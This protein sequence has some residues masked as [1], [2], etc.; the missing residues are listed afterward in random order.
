[1]AEY[2]HHHYKKCNVTTVFLLSNILQHIYSISNKRTN[3]SPEM[4]IYKTDRFS[5]EVCWTAT[6]KK[7]KRDPLPFAALRCC[8]KPSLSYGWPVRS[9]ASE[10]ASSPAPRRP[11]STPLRSRRRPL[12]RPL[13]RPSTER[14]KIPSS[15]RLHQLRRHWVRLQFPSRTPTPNRA[16]NTRRNSP[17]KM[18]PN[19]RTRKGRPSTPTAAL[20]PATP[21]TIAPSL[22]TASTTSSTVSSI[23]YL[24][25]SNRSRSRRPT[26]IRCRNCS[27]KRRSHWIR[28][29]QPMWG[30]WKRH[31]QSRNLF[32]KNR[33]LLMA[34][35]FY[36]I[37]MGKKF[38]SV[39]GS[40][41]SD[42]IHLNMMNRKGGK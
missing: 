42:I 24:R 37:F 4:L 7:R 25:R 22:T 14:R 28:A 26:S 39:N 16:R 20:T 36:I 2:I 35:L 5:L 17:K 12:S 21:A 11:V 30:W 19:R 13:L 31:P 41:S 32:E 3:S 15:C 34:L 38:T 33:C 23:R 18:V 10:S 6:G 27:Q 40:D 9:R 29:I 1:M 8:T